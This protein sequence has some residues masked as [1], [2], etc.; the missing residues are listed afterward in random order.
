LSVRVRLS[1]LLRE[2]AA[3]NETVQVEGGTPVECVH[4]LV[5]LFPDLRALL[6]DKNGTLRPQVWFFVNGEKLTPDD[7]ERALSDGDELS[8]LIAISGG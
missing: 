3:G 4:G 1:T 8:L 5:A 7:L 2:R 6:F